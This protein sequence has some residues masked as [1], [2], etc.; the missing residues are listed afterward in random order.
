[1]F[2]SFFHGVSDYF[3]IDEELLKWLENPKL[4]EIT[5]EQRA[6]IEALDL[7]ELRELFLERLSEQEERHD[8]GNRWIGTGGT[9]P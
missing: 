3:L 8:G 7:D 1:A 6:Q 9:S 2:A 4:P 5:D